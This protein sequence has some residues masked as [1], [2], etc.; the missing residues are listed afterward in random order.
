MS[1]TAAALLRTYDE[2]LR[3]AKEVVHAS[4][5]SRLGP[6][7]LGVYGGTHGFIT[8]WELGDAEAIPELVAAALERF[9]ADPAIV[10]VEWKTRAHDAEPGLHEALLAHGFVPGEPESIMIGE[11]AALAVDVPLPAGVVLRR[12]TAAADVRAMS[13]MQ[14]EVFGDG[15][16]SAEAMADDLLRRIAAGAE[17]E[18]WVAEADGRI[19]SA[20]RID[21]VAGTEFAGI[22]GGS[23]VLEWRGRG[24]YRAL[25]AARARAAIAAGK[26][27]INSDSTGYSRPILERSGFVKVSETTPYVWR[28][29]AS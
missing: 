25:T 28:R 17:M 18:L 11:A 26:R 14:A 15:D 2:Q 27:Y 7:H 1:D 5:V 10:E 22:W 29:E 3:G 4:S 9:R 12:V 23:T 20:G 6:L 21:P 19:I 24:V 16:D 8:G 13:R